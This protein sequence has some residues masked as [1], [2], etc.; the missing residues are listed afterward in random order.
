VGF[1]SGAESILQNPMGNILLT[2]DKNKSKP[3]IVIDDWEDATEQQKKYLTIHKDKLIQR[4][5]RK[6]NHTN[7]WQFGLLRNHQN[8]RDNIGKPCIYVKMITRSSEVA[9]IG[10]VGYF[11]GSLLCII[12]STTV[13]LNK[14]VNYLNSVQFRTHWTSSG[15]FR[16]LHR[17]LSNTVV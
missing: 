14:V 12:P 6:F 9:W 4:K 10:T 8:I 1:V 2:Y 15:R 11:G 13:D 3:Y 5:V 7:W 17:V 16:I